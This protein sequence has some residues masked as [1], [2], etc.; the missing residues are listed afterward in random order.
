MVVFEKVREYKVKL[1]CNKE[2]FGIVIDTFTEFIFFSK[3]HASTLFLIYIYIYK[4]IYF[5]F[6]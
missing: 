6:I 1:S 2:E 4:R 5:F 3:G